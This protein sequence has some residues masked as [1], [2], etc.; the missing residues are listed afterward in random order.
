M[1]VNDQDMY[2]DS[3]SIFSLSGFL[4]KNNDLLFRNLK[5]VRQILKSEIVKC[6]DY[7]TKQQTVLLEQCVT[8]S[9]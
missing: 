2:Q 8:D 9:G 1:E 4:D 7:K 6:G 3:Y 5:E